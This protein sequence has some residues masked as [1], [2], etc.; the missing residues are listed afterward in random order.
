MKLR[1]KPTSDLT[2]MREGS[3]LINSTHIS[4]ANATLMVKT[5][6]KEINIFLPTYCGEEVVMD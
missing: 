4:L 5:K 3:V 2:I 6:V 1:D